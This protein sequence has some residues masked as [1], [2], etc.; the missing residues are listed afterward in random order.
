[1]LS[2]SV[3]TDPLFVAIFMHCKFTPS[4]LSPVPIYTP[5]WR[6]TTW[7]KVSCLRKKH[8]GKDHTRTTDLQVESPSLVYSA[9]LELLG[10]R[11]CPNLNCSL[12]TADKQLS[13]TSSSCFSKRSRSKTTLFITRWGWICRSI[14]LK[15]IVLK[16][17]KIKDENQASFFR[18]M[19]TLRCKWQ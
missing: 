19:S 9:Y 17:D 11:A 15:I 5:G 6:E 8:D 2:V 13:S 7:S 10:L 14:S 16:M 18:H 12:A 4:I 1:M 3:F